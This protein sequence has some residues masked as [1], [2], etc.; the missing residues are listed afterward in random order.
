M[1]EHSLI[2]K[3]NGGWGGELLDGGSGKEATFGM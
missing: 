2:G 3:G 1:E